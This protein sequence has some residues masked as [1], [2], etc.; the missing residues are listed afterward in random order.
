M[1]K[2]IIKRFAS[3][4]MV[5]VIVCSFSMSA[6]AAD[7]AVVPSRDSAVSQED[8]VEPLGAGSIIASNVGTIYGGSGIISVNLPKG[9]FWAD[10]VAGIGYTS[11]SGI[12]TVTALTPDNRN[13]YLGTLS[14]SGSQTISQEL[15]YAPAGTYLFYFESGIQSPIEVY[16]R[17]YD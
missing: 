2:S 17:I 15:S 13:L 7:S 8:G 12:V 1:M 9:N 6:F 3:I 11:E 10:I 5:L 4:F 14:G 16:A